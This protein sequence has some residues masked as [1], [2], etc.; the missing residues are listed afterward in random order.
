[1]RQ[2]GRRMV[3]LVLLA[4][5]G[6]TADRGPLPMPAPLPA[7]EPTHLPR[8]HHVQLNTLD[9]DAAIDWYLSV[10]PSAERTEV[11][12]LP[13]IRAE[14]LLLFREVATRPPGAF[15][16]SVGRSD[17][18][19]AFWH[20]GAFV[21]TTDLDRR[22]RGLG[23]LLLPLYT[24]PDDEDGVW[25]SGLA[26]YPGVRTRDQMT[27]DVEARPRPGGFAYVLGPDGAL[28]EL[29]GGPRTQPAFSHVHFFHER[30]LCAA[31]WYVEHLGMALPPIRSEDGTET[32]RP[33]WDPCDVPP[34]PPTWPSLERQGTLRHPRGTVRYG[35]G[36]MSWYPRP[37]AGGRCGGARPFAPS[38]GQVYDHVAFTVD[39]LDAAFARLQAAGVT[40]LRTP[41]PWGGTRA[42]MIQDP[43]GLAIELLESAGA[44][45][46]G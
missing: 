2:L 15:D 14:M 21:N 40:I 16:A 25:R 4:G 39:D 20:I 36:T 9:A 22:L 46:V 28:V 13:A 3:L 35:N 37:C 27:P 33:P 11:R 38:R 18:Q 17:P 26:P 34:G 41:H 24:S 44:P 42:I 23:V 45:P 32:P 10:W 43:D 5:A 29:T 12:G 7:Q 8:L 30:P 31:N 6:Q 1:M 19:S